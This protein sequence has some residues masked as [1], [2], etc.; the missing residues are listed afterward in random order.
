MT[1]QSRL[2][3]FLWH[4]PGAT[5]K[6]ASKELGI[7]YLAARLANYRLKKRADIDRL[8]P[9]CFKPTFFGLVCHTCGY[10]GDHPKVPE[11]VFSS[12]SPVHG[13][14]PFGG[15]GG[16]TVPRRDHN[17][18]L[19]LSYGI[20]NVSHLCGKPDDPFLERCKSMLWAELKN[21]MLD[22]GI[23]EEA[24][25][26]LVKEVSEFRYRYP[27]LTRARGAADQIVGNLMALVRLRHPNR[28]TVSHPTVLEADC[29]GH[30]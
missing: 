10:E 12:Q 1:T 11:V 27:S 25:R 20:A 3:R 18:R 24:A 23:T 21:A 22:D 15:L 2:F 19:I 8:C 17:G 14:Q 16:Q 9:E 4:N 26:L 29:D 7:S 6:A 28:F 30:E 5:L 13:L